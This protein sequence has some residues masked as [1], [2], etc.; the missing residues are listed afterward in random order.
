MSQTDEATT[1]PEHGRQTIIVVGTWQAQPVYK[2][3]SRIPTLFREFNFEFVDEKDIT[4]FLEESSADERH[5]QIAGVIEQVTP[6]YN[7]MERTVAQNRW[8]WVTFPFL[9]MNA[10]WPLWGEDPRHQIAD[11]L[12]DIGRYH[13]ADRAA[14]QVAKDAE[15]SGEVLSDDILYDKYIEATD[16][17]LSVA[18][19]ILLTDWINIITLDLK[20]DIKMFDFIY[21]NFRE[22]KLFNRPDSPSGHIYMKICSDLLRFIPLRPSSNLEKRKLELTYFLTGYEGLSDLQA[23][24]HPAIAGILN[25]KWLGSDA[26][27]RNYSYDLSFREYMVNYISWRHWIA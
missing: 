1:T 5:S 11:E 12:Y 26:I 6:F 9:K 27:Y 2:I 13:F 20:T 17:L 24:I 25:I 19:D 3:L 16:G 18:R 10:F 22:T 21:E 8:F 15:L 14:A 7:P 23:P 4:S